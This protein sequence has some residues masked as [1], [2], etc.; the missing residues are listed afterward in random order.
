M[1]EEQRPAVRVRGFQSSP[2]ANA[3][4]SEEPHCRAHRS[5]ARDVGRG[6]SRG[7]AGR[8]SGGP[9][10]AA[11]HDPETTSTRP[12]IAGCRKR[13]SEEDGAVDDGERRARDTAR[14]PPSPDRNPPGR[15]STAASRSPPEIAPSAIAAASGPRSG[16]WS[17]S[18]A[19]ANGR[20]RDGAAHHRARD[21]ANRRHAAQAMLAQEP[22]ERVAERAKQQHRRSEERVETAAQL[23]SHSS[24]TPTIPTARP[25]SPRPRERSS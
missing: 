20:E 11:S 12:A 6:D 2:G 9:C 25:R 21:R 5:P 13:L 16:A 14:P 17:G 23:Q 8:A 22:A 3:Q 1:R 4:H 19:S 24:A 10:E 15:C 18:V 7:A